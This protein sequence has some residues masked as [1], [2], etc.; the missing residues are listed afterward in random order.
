MSTIRSKIIFLFGLCSLVLSFVPTSVGA[1]APAAV[2]LQTTLTPTGCIH[3]QAQPNVVLGHYGVGPLD[4]PTAGW[5]LYTNA[6]YYVYGSPSGGEFHGPYNFGGPYSEPLTW[7][8]L[9]YVDFNVTT[10]DPGAGYYVDMCPPPGSTATAS[11]SPV[12]TSSATASPLTTAIGTST[13]TPA[14]CVDYVLPIGGAAVNIPVGL[15]YTLRALFGII[16]AFPP[17]TVWDVPSVATVWPFP[18]GTYVFRGW[19]DASDPAVLKICPPMATVTATS[20][21]TVSPTVTATSTVLPT[22]TRTASRT[23]TATRTPSVTLT[24][25][26]TA[27]ASNTSTATATVPPSATATVPPSATTDPD[28]ITDPNLDGLDCEI[29]ANQQTQISLQLTEIA[30]GNIA[31]ASVPAVLGPSALSTAVGVSF[32]TIEAILCEKEPCAGAQEISSAVSDFVSGLAGLSAP[33]CTDTAIGIGSPGGF[34]VPPSSEGFCFL[35]DTTSMIRA[36]MRLFSVFSFSLLL[37]RYFN[38][39]LQRDGGT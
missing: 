13:A 31:T 14:P 4:P 12:V 2:R 6:A 3:Y 38:R 26:S 16:R 39:T 24:R 37:Y 9:T 5:V 36:I 23:R 11:L 27:T 21:A 17:G 18:A 15:G 19:G 34:Y 28:C 29:V 33:E 35:L 32:A 22:L 10:Q 20:T 30:Q 1:G 8:D 25:T 7:F